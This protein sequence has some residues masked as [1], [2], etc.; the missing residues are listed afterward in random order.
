[1]YE[2][3]EVVK[4]ASLLAQVQFDGVTYRSWT[5]IMFRL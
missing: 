5:A 1:M 2:M 3:S 4:P